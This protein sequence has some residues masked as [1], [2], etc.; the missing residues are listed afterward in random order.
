MSKKDYYSVLDV[1]RSAAADE[2]K[3][4]Y[5]KLAMKYHP[6]KNPGDKRAEDRFKE[7]TEAYEVLGD[8]KKRELYDQFGFA[9][10]NGGFGGGGGQPGSPNPGGPGFGGFGG[11]SGQQAEGFQDVF[12][13]IFG[14]VF[15]ANP[16]TRGPRRQRGADLRYT[17]NISMEEA[18]IGAERTISFVRSRNNREEN[19]KLSVKIPAGVGQGQRLKLALEGDGGPNGGA[20]GDLYVIV[21]IQDHSIFKRE[22]DDVILDLPIAYTDA[23]LGTTAEVPT[24]TNKVSLKIPAGTQSGQVF[25]LKGKGFPRVGGF[26]TGDMLVRITVDTPINVSGRQKEL[27]EELAKGTGETPLVKAFK[28]KVQQA[29][30]NRK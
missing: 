15:G 10:N 13:D 18:A 17:L 28:E 24:L 25:R 5:R 11:F 21:N 30:R 26:G 16:R 6:D 4:S 22:E 3:K 23:I 8:A 7:I 12:S 19:A 2:I 9:G 20:N 14:D 29:S 1:P 27:I